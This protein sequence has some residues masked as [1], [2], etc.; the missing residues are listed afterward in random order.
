[1][2]APLW[3]LKNLSGMWRE[4]WRSP[5]E[6]RRSQSAKLRLLVRHA[7]RRSPSYR[8]LLERQGLGPADIRGI[9]DLPAL[10]VISKEQLRDALPREAFPAPAGF[11]EVATSGSTGFPLRLLFFRE[12]NSRL[13]VNWLRPLLAHGVRPWHRRFEITG[14][15]NLPVGEKWYQQLGLWRRR[16]VSVFRSPA[17]WEEAFRSARPRVLYGYT[18]SIKIFARHLLDRGVRDI[19]PRFIFGVSDVMDQECR[20]LVMAAFGRRIVDIYGAAEGGCIAWEC[21]ICDGYHVN[22]DTVIVE[23]LQAGRPASPGTP[24]RITITNLHSRALPIIRYDLEDIGVAG[25]AAPVCGRGLPLMKVVAGRSDACVILPSGRRLSPL[26][27]FAIMKPIKG[28]ARWRVVQDVAG[29]VEISVVPV[30]D[31]SPDQAG[32]I[33]RAVAAETG[34]QVRVKVTPVDRIP[35]DPTG[36]VR[37]VVSRV[38][39]RLDQGS[40]FENIVS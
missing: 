33:R 12:D 31:F 26:F 8:R 13:N 17:D 4:Q 25:A 7:W 15:H 9:D 38:A 28:V 35:P 37:A 18:G 36:K 22:A 39:E 30:A 23:F 3:Q 21:P 24:G 34:E 1:M 2:K 20:E 29:G 14:P 5:E 10:P 11:V 19:R 40:G 27:F 6:L 32:R 16:V